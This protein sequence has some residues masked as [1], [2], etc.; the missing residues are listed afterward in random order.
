M[1]R[2]DD[3]YA[4][5]FQHDP[6]Y[7]AP[8]PNLEESRRWAKVGEYLSRIAAPERHGGAR[9]L[10][11][12]DV[13]CG[14]GWM[15]RLAS[16]FGDCE[17]I[18]P[19]ENVIDFARTLF[20]EL[21]FHSGTI[22]ELMRS[23]DFAP[24]DVV[25]CSEVLEHVEEKDAFIA[26]MRD[27][28][29]PGGHLIVTTPRAEQF[30]RYRQSGY[31]LQPVEA[32]L[33]ERDLGALLERHGFSAMAHDRIYDDLPSLSRFHRV[34]AGGRLASTLDRWRLAW[35]TRALRHVGAIYQIWWCS[36]RPLEPLIEGGEI[37]RPGL[38]PSA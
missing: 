9:R 33:T 4:R 35:L 5:L 12:L 37:A 18:D 13:G 38:P 1:N 23:P 29:V 22:E 28:L 8:F 25:L 27:C 14:R 6:T 36:K 24:Y 19:V 17:G 11:I 10:R 26:T 34:L 20:P 30:E 21:P 31:D 16:V 32:W 2:H 15:T 3:Y 7:S